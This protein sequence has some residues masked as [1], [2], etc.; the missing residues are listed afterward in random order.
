[1]TRPAGFRRLITIT[2]SVTYQHVQMA[3]LRS[4]R[5]SLILLP[6]VASSFIFL[7]PPIVYSG[8]PACLHVPIDYPTI[9]E[10]ITAAQPG[11]AIY[12][13]RGTYSGP[14]VV[15]KSLAIIGTGVG[16]SIID[17]RSLPGAVMRI[18]ASNTS[19]SGF[20]IGN[21]GVGGKAIRVEQA[22]NVSITNNGLSSDLVS[23]RSTGAGVDLYLS[24]NS[25][26][27]NNQFSYNLYE[28]NLTRSDYNR[29]SNNRPVQKN[30][31]GVMLT[32][33]SH[34]TVVGNG[35]LAGDEGVEIS[36]SLS[37]QNNV[38][39]NLF[40]SLNFTAVF[41][42]SFPSGNIL[43]SNN[44][45]LNHI[46][47][48]LQNSTGNI[49]YHNNFVRNKFRHVNSVVSGD[50][51]LNHWDNSTLGALR[52]GGNYWDN[53]TGSD[54]NNDGI[55]DTNLPANGLDQHPLTVPYLTIPLAVAGV[56]PSVLGGPAPL[57]VT[58]TADVVG[59]FTPYS[60]LWNF[61]DTTPNSNKTM[62]VHT[63][64]A[65]GNYTIGVLVMDRTGIRSLGTAQV[66]VQPG[67]AG[68][69]NIYFLVAFGIAA[70]VTG[71]AFVVYWR[72]RR[73]HG[74]TVVPSGAKPS[75]TLVKTPK[76][77]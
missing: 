12:V 7:L 18:T 45:Q 50:G 29:I 48:D 55:G 43:S 36:G 58:F 67:G 71:A 14:I 22:D 53:Y 31:V 34:N 37:S 21:T 3:S 33:S 6:L 57:T 35:F 74:G 38:T 72:Q 51:L 40:K 46:G 9:Q 32:N 49:F 1:M 11:Y 26:V 19:I 28:V 61:G 54:T 17:G 8:C 70:S 23:L 27:D 24:N 75:R 65:A 2:G 42:L 60:Y 66:L 69:V 77:R 59:S 62:P 44:F 15:D 25:V 39:G 52:P 63:Y 4:L 56:T 73:Q 20:S 5:L 10:A 64:T 41:L 30:L 13:S 16:N 68:G 47:I 76:A